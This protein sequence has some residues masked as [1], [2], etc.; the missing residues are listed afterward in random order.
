MFTV[1]GSMS[2]IPLHAKS[3]SL[4]TF[5]S[6]KSHPCATENSPV[7]H[8]VVSWSFSF[9]PYTK[10]FHCFPK[11]KSTISLHKN[12]FCASRSYLC[13]K[14]C[15]NY[16]RDK[17]GCRFS[18]MKIMCILYYLISYIYFTSYVHVLTFYNW[19]Q[20]SHFFFRQLL[21]TEMF[22]LHLNINRLAID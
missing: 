6:R 10:G 18:S 12:M 19:N 14:V 8:H 17:S 22:C 16:D 4:H 13:V 1:L 5:T 20:T 9:G 11:T 15:N 21:I 3:F 7:Q 2:I